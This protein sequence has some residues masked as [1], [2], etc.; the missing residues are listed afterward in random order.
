M[1]TT[2]TLPGG[3]CTLLDDADLTN[4]QVKQLR[5]SAR[6]AAAIATKLQASGFDE[7]DP[8]TWATIA[9]LSDDD[10]DVLDEF[11]RTAVITRLSEWN[12]DGVDRPVTIEDVDNLPRPVYVP[13]TV[14]AADIKLG[15]DDFGMDGAADP[16][17]PTDGYRW[18]CANC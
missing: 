16:K 14:A 10:D 11:Q 1:S 12:V 6:H 17:A 15:D 5:R 4:R 8:S 9:S 3:S 2:V 13:L 18:P 7:K